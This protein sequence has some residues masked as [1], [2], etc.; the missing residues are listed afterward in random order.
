MLDQLGRS[1]PYKAVQ[2][3]KEI[4]LFAESQKSKDAPSTSPM[5]VNINF[6]PAKTQTED[7]DYIDISEQQKLKMNRENTPPHK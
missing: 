3:W 6:V 1:D 2:A 7:T 5:N 4:T